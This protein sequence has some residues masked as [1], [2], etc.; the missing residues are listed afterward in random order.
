MTKKDYVLLANVLRNIA[1]RAR[2][3]EVTFNDVLNEFIKCLEQDNPKFKRS[4]F[5][6]AVFRN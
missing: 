1:N 6:E 2:Y 4:K 5:E 3:G